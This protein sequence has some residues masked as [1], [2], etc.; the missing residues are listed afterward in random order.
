MESIYDV[1]HLT[2]TPFKS[3]TSPKLLYSSES[4]KDCSE[5][6]YHAAYAFYKKQSYSINWGIL[7]LG[8]KWIVW[9]LLGQE[10]EIFYSCRRSETDEGTGH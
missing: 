2:I 1:Y 6:A 5:Q 10:L 3:P 7:P 8:N 4:S 9:N